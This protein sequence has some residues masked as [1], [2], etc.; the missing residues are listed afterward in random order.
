MEDRFETDEENMA[1][2]MAQILPREDAMQ[3]FSPFYNEVWQYYTAHLSMMNLFAEI[4]K[5]QQAFSEF[6]QWC[7]REQCP[8]LFAAALALRRRKLQEP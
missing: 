4:P 6:L 1:D 7:K 3:C 8:E 5:S 2:Y